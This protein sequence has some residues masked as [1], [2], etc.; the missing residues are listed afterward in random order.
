MS[1][2]KIKYEIRAAAKDDFVINEIQEIDDTRTTTRH[3]YVHSSSAEVIREFDSVI[4]LSI[5]LCF[6]TIY[7]YAVMTTILI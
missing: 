3:T 7:H 4:G 5:L 1:S 2:L 6:F